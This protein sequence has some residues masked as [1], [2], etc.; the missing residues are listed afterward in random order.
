MKKTIQTLCI[1]L[2]STM[3]LT[4]CSLF[5][6]EDKKISEALVGTFEEE[7]MT[8]YTVKFEKVKW[9]FD[10]NGEVSF[11]ANSERVGNTKFTGKWEVKDKALTI[12][13]DNVKSDEEEFSEKEKEDIIENIE[14]QF[15]SCEITSYDDKKIIFKDKEG[16]KHTLTKSKD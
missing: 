4:S 16:E 10:K 13:L 2:L 5:K 6:S 7:E 15:K 3:T 14:K 9:D 12:K 11:S 1:L 8:L